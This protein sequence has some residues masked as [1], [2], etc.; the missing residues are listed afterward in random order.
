T[1]ERAVQALYG[2]PDAALVEMGDFVGATL[3]YL[4]RHPAKRLALAGGFAKIGK[5]A[6]GHLDLHSARSALDLD[7]LSGELVELGVPAKRAALGEARTAAALLA[8]AQ[9]TDVPLAQRVARR[10]GTVAA[11]ILGPGTRIEV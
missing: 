7:A 4:R 2:L 5:L 3:K 10:A 11:Q 9:D 8:V 6:Q 1:S